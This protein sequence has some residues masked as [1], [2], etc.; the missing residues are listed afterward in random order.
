M[1]KVSVE[2]VRKPVFLIEYEQKDITAYISPFVLSVT[3][4]DHEHGKSDEI[5]IQIEDSAHLWKSSWY[6]Q[7]G[8]ILT[9]K[10]GYEDEPLLPCGSFE[11]DELEFNGP[12]A[13]LNL[14]G[15]GT[16]ITKALRQKNTQSYENMTL[17]QIAQQIA[18]K[19]KLAL[20]GKVKDI[21]IKRITQKEE[22]DLAFLKRIAEDYGYVFEI[23]D[24]RLVFYEIAALESTDTVFVIDRKD[25]ITYTF[26][27]KTHEI[28]K[29]CTVSYFDPKRKR[30]YTHTEQAKGIVKGDILKIT[31]RCENKQQ[32][33]EKA[34]AALARKNGLQTEGTITVTGT[35]RL[36]AGTNIEITGLFTL[37][38]KY[39]IQTSRHII[40]RYSGYRTEIEVKR[41]V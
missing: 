29:A 22:R 21:R 20:V 33:I 10:I 14:R 9:L 11:I 16:N 7:K 28:Y 8:D 25:M 30:L 34:K 23:V 32:A 1:E 4:T 3:Y 40:D 26:R 2:K 35:P 6:P 38:G 36:V 41:V 5:D 13:T 31:E 17:K 24:N 19:H 37:N 12:P 18:K 15:I 39:H 27:D